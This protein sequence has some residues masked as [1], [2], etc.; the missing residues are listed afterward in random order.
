[1]DG[2]FSNLYEWNFSLLYRGAMGT[3]TRG[4]ENVANKAAAGR[5]FAQARLERNK[6][7]RPGNA[8]R[9]EQV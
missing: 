2:R 7:Q 3:H 8:N 9:S 6:Q 1:M 5:G 4:Q